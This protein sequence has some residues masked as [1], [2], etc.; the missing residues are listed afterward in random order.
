[1]RPAPAIFGFGVMVM[2]AL[3]AALH[4]QTGAAAS[5]GVP[6]LSGDWAMTL[7]N[8][9][10]GGGIGQ[11]LSSVDPGGFLRG[12]EPDIPYLPKALAKTL[13][14][15]PP[16]GSDGKYETTTDPN[17]HYCE[18]LGLGRIFMA[19]AKTRFVQTPEAVYILHEIG[20]TF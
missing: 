7:T 11:S 13:S 8:V 12:K 1:M 4:A 17:I 20:P 3:P 15:V 14:E 9:Q 5:S 16:T 6:D 19:P 2:L 10:H 18:P